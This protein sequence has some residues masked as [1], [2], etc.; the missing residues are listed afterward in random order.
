MESRRLLRRQTFADAR[1]RGRVSVFPMTDRNKSTHRV[2]PKQQL[3]EFDRQAAAEGH[4]VQ[5]LPRLSPL[6]RR[7]M[8]DDGDTRDRL[9]TST[10]RSN[11]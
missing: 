8:D 10:H 4:A 1:R 11:A 7:V 5:F 2:L 9:L 6:R 3:D